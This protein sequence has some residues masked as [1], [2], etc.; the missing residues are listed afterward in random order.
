[1]PPPGGKRTSL[2]SY[3][4]GGF[5]SQNDITQFRNVFQPDQ[6]I[7]SLATRWSRPSTSACECGIIRSATTLYIRLDRT[8]R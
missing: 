3:T 6:G 7:F 4:W 2:A 5:G 1:M 8:I